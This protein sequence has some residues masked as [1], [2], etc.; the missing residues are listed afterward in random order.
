LTHVKFDGVFQ[1][2]F[3]NHLLFLTVARLKL[4]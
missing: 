1:G 3:L 2:Y 4:P